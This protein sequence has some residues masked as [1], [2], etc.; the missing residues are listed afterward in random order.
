MVPMSVQAQSTIP[1]AASNALDDALAKTPIIVDIINNLL[2]IAFTKAH[3]HALTG[4]LQ[5]AMEQIQV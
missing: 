2:V 1:S 4:H 5:Q 3:F